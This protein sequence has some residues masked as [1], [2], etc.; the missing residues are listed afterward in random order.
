MRKS[1]F[2][3]ENADLDQ[4]EGFEG[5]E[6]LEAADIVEE[7]DAGTEEIT[8]IADAVEEGTDAGDQMQQV[9]ELVADAVENGE[10]LDPVAA[11]AVRISVEAI[12]ARVGADPK[13]VYSLY[14]VENF[15]S[16]SSRKANSRIAL[17]GVGEF[18]KDLW[19]KIKAALK[20]MWDKMKAFWAK[21]VSTLGRLTKALEKTK[22]RVKASSGK[23]TGKA[24]VEKAPS[25]LVSAF[26][27]KGDLDAARVTSYLDSIAAA[28]STTEE[29][30]K[31]VTKLKSLSGQKVLTLDGFK[32]QVESGSEKLQKGFEFQAIGG[33]T[34][35]TALKLSDDGK[36]VT[37]NTE[38]TP[39]DGKDEEA[40]MAI[41]TKSQLEAVVQKALDMVKGQVAMKKN[42][43]KI[44]QET[45]AV[46]A[47]FGQMINE[48]EGDKE[49]LRAVL[50]ASYRLNASAA[51][52]HSIV[53]TQT[54]RAA[55]ATIAF[56]NANL[57]QYA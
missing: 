9:E 15:Q 47:A 28:G 52:V 16:A 21:H 35:K 42:G 10:G 5:G 27:G 48:S 8:E 13:A 37:V 38:R 14:A 57:K 46:L 45:N 36:S 12:C 50:S 18:L 40:G 31:V 41:A 26:A 6:E 34:V 2:A 44:E 22:A 24:Y 29:V 43:E 25:G 1:L 7:T 54:V 4:V 20:K 39:F 11:E 3:L 56:V 51:K 49:A 30:E 17:E 53:T 33:D 19:A 23:I 32:S 55:K